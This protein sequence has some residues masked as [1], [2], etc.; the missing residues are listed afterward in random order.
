L[1]FFIDSFGELG[2]ATCEFVGGLVVLFCLS[3]EAELFLVAI[4]C[5]FGFGFVNVG[6]ELF[7]FCF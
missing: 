1:L 6:S 5:G 4:V 2:V 3:H 7:Y